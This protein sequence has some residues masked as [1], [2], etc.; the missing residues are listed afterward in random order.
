MFALFLLEKKTYLLTTLAR[1]Q[2]T[3]LQSC[4]FRIKQLLLNDKT[5]KSPGSVAQ[6]N[7]KFSSMNSMVLCYTSPKVKI[8]LPLNPSLEVH[9]ALNHY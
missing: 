1:A 6:P 7:I 3:S 5:E 8:K 2:S 4:Q 9:R